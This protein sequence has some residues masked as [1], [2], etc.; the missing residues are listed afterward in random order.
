MFVF[1]WAAVMLIFYELLLVNNFPYHY[2]CTS[3][4]KYVIRITIFVTLVFSS[5]SFSLLTYWLFRCG[6]H[7]L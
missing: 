3:V 7:L 6:T 5:S 2:S 4:N 1:F